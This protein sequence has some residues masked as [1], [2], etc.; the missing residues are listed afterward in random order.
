MIYLDNNATTPADKRVID[1]MMPYFRDIYSNPSSIYRF[2]QSAKRA[3]ED[4]RA[5]IAG[6][7][8]ADPREI[9]F[10]SGGTESDNTA[11]KGIAFMLQD[12]GRHIITSKV[13]HHA[14]LR[15][16]E[17]LEKL[18]FKVTYLDVDE[19]GL[20]DLKLL[21]RSIKKETILV[22]IMYANNEVGTIQ[23]IEEIAA[24]CRD[25]GVYLHTD[26]VQ[27]IG[28]VEVDVKK[29][30][31]DLLSLSAH[32][33]YGPKGVGVLYVK[34]GVKFFP[35][36]QGGGHEGGRRSG[37]ENVPGIVGLG[38][39]ARIAKIE[40][41]QKEKKIKPLRNRL[42]K[43]IKED[44]PEVKVNG[45]PEKRLWNTLNICVK[46]IEG[47]SVLINLDFENICAS[48]GSACTSGS[49]E[50]SHVLLAMGISHEDAHGSLRFSLGKDT[51]A[52]DI[53]RVIEVLPPIVKKLRK[54]S[55]FWQES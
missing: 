17:F 15:P 4:A 5:S 2:A 22:S 53:D 21:E 25:K 29:L 20:I 7:L 32:K 40:S 38:E 39:A 11:I 9:V 28:R 14:V 36:L 43:A 49:L 51:T 24:I 47:E 19:Y 44:I 46:H 41:N 52:E 54:I 45:H 55:P 31:V 48:S 12:K 30:G 26:A 34:K 18:G 6:L 35:L 13:E 23:P 33:M 50:P 3:V 37:T 16:C 27:A 10:T 1:K 8:S 42:E